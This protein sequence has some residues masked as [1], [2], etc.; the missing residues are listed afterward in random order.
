MGWGNIGLSWTRYAK[1]RPTSHCDRCHL[2]YPEAGDGCPH[3]SHVKDHELQEFLQE[4]K[5]KRGKSTTLVVTL[6]AALTLYMIIVL[7]VL[8]GYMQ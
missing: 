3:C 7:F 5:V 1:A 8:P 6:I 4:L 2:D